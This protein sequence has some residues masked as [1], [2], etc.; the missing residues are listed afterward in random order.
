M[1]NLERKLEQLEAK[2]ITIKT[3]STE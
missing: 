2:I 1:K 3:G